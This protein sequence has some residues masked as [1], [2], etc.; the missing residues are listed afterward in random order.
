M[1]T[2]DNLIQKFQ[3]SFDWTFQTVW[4]DIVGTLNSPKL[5][6]SCPESSQSSFLLKSDVFQNSP[7]SH[8]IFGLLLECHDAKHLIILPKSSSQDR[9]AI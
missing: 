9:L 7:K 2:R 6:K 5:S 3:S 4:R 8:Q 1:K